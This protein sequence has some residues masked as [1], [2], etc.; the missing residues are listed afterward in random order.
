MIQDNFPSNASTL[1]YKEQKC[2]DGGHS[3]IIWTDGSRTGGDSRLH[4]FILEV[5]MLTF[6]QCE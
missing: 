4:E 3:F 6:Q 5:K 2:D 1:L